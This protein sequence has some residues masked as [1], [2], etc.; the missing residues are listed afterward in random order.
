MKKVITHNGS[1]HADDV[2]GV[3]TLQLHFGVENVEVIRTRDEAVIASGDV[4]LDVG[5][6]YD[7]ERQRFDHH[8]NGAPGRDNGIPY[9]AFGLIWKHYGEQVAGSAE[10]A[11]V[12]EKR[13]VI[14]IDAVDNAISLYDQKNPEISPITINDIFGLMRPVWNS[15]EDVDVGFKEACAIARQLLE[16]SMAHAAA[17][18][19]EKNL[20]QQVYESAPDKRIMISEVAISAH[21]FIDYPECLFLISPRD[22]GNWKATGVREGRDSFAIRKAFPHEW[23][24]LRDQELATAS[25]IS[26][27]IFCHKTG[28]LFV[29]KSKE[30][31]VEATKKALASA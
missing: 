8:Q 30:G 29:V 22:D 17:E 24:G 13:L 11:E 1:F 25:G 10:A 26:D 31:A 6:I 4:V 16:R 3:A 27:A 19:A 18:I 5:G 2:F 28:Y 20:A 7:P 15:D 12:I 9:A 21:F 14:P 23:R